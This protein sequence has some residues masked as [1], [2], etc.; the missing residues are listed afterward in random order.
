MV[1]G[2]RVGVGKKV[3][4]L[5]YMEMKDKENRCGQKGSG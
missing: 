5:A 3:G 1:K 4:K 2:K